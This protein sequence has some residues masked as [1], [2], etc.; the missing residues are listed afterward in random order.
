MF[1]WTEYIKIFTALLVIVN[2][3]GVLP[4]FVSLTGHQSA[5]ERR[6]T[7]LVSSVTMGVVLMAACLL[8]DSLLRF[9]GISVAS[10][11]V[12]GGILI[13]LIAVA[14]FHAQPSASKQTP[15]EAA[16]AG[17]KAD[18]AVVPLAVPLLSGPGA[19]STV[20]IY[21]HQLPDWK[22]AGLLLAVCLLVALTVWLTLRLAIPIG[23]ALG[24][25]GINIVTRLMG[26]ILAA[27]AV[28][29]LVG[30]VTVLLPGLVQR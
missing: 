1:V 29:V 9:F 19:I 4:I 17:E 12:G 24:R 25:T 21:A 18:V 30:G 16:E 23:N 5:K 22:H 6:R 28:E 15:E 14:M 27:I 2:P 8:G 3:I 26:L 7:A 10:F 11:R 13:L 20:I